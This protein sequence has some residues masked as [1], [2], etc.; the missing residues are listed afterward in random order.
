[1][2]IYQG[3]SIYN[4][5]GGGG[6]GS[7]GSWENITDEA[8]WAGVSQFNFYDRQLLYNSAVNLVYFSAKAAGIVLN[9]ANAKRVFVLPNSLKF[10]GHVY[11]LGSPCM[12]TVENGNPKFRPFYYTK[13]DMPVVALSNFWSYDSP[14]QSPSLFKE[15]EVQIFSLLDESKYPTAGFEG[16]C[17]SGMFPVEQV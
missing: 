7:G 3:D 14:Y 12:A 10:L 2:G 9:P 16:F 8:S 13:G 1:M 17:A 5:G 4:N 6:G 11:I 15:R